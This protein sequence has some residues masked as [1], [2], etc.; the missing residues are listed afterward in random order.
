MY[1]YM[2]MTCIYLYLSHIYIYIYIGTGLRAATASTMYSMFFWHEGEHQKEHSRARF[3]ARRK[4]LK[5]TSA[6]NTKKPFF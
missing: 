5:T 4:P 6:Q 2:Y 1:M 3:C